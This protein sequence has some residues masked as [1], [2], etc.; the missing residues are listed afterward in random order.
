MLILFFSVWE[1]HVDCTALLLS[2][3]ELTIN[4]RQFESQ[5]ATKIILSP[6]AELCRAAH[7]AM[8]QIAK[9][10]ASTFITTIGN[11]FDRNVEV[12]A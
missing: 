6:Q 7:R 10:R 11:H 1:A 4:Y 8:C 2:L 12:L 9:S 3:L 5:F